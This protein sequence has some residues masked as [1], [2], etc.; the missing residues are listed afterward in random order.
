MRGHNLIGRFTIPYER[1][2]IYEGITEDLQIPVGVE[3]DWWE[4]DEYLLDTAPTDVVDD[5]YD[6]SSEVPGKGRRWVPHYKIPAITAQLIQGRIAENQ[7]GFYNTDTLRIVLNVGQILPIIPDLCSHP[8]RHIRDRIMFRGEIFIPVKVN[9]RGHMGYD[10]AVVTID[11]NQ[12]NPEEMVNDPQ[13]QDFATPTQ[14]PV[15]NMPDVDDMENAG[16]DS[17]DQVYDIPAPPGI[18][19]LPFDPNASDPYL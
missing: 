5:I 11:C 6:V 16:S 19:R 10:F 8:D 9:P 15:A 3:I 2:S 14:M 4:W 17:F 12:V 13:F 1:D 18:P 7:R